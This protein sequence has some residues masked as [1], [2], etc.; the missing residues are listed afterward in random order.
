MGVKQLWRTVRVS[1]LTKPFA[2]H[3]LSLSYDVL[4]SV[5]DHLPFP[6][7]TEKMTMKHR[8]SKEDGGGELEWVPQ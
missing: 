8:K 5:S 1:L 7:M 6:T 4:D 3:Y 2:P